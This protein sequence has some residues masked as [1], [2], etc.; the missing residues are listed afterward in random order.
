M[1]TLENL[2]PQG[3][4]NW[5]AK[6]CGIP[7]PSYHEEEL[8]A[9]VA[10]WA[11]EKGYYGGQDKVGNLRLVKPA[12]PGKDHLPSVCL[13]AHFDMVPQS[14]KEF[15]FLTQP[16]TPVVKGNYV[17]ADE[18]TL[19]ADNGIGLASI[20]AIFDDEE[21]V[22]GPLEAILTRNEE[23]SMIG[24]FQLQ[25]NW[26]QSDYLINTD[27]EEIGELYLGCAGGYDVELSR[28]YEFKAL[29]PESKLYRVSLSGFRGGHSG[30][31]IHTNRESA[32]QYLNKALFLTY[33]DVKFNICE[34]FSGQALNAI[35]R[36]ATAV[37]VVRAENQ[38]AFKQAWAK[39]SATVLSIVKLAEENGEFKTEFL[40]TAEEHPEYKRISCSL[41]PNLLGF[42][43]NIPNGV[44][45]KSDV[46]AD[47]IE[48]SLSVGVVRL[49][50]EEGFSYKILARSTNDDAN[51]L[52]VLELQAL[53]QMGGFD[54]KYHGRYPG[55]QP[56]KNAFSDFVA[57]T[58]AEVMN[59]DISVKVIHAGLEC[60]IIKGHYPNMKI[61]SIGPNIYNPHTPKEH[62]D[63]ASTAQYYET[64]RQILGNLEQML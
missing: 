27:S 23:V 26:L 17:Y 39:A 55:W 19:G 61:V 57:K 31:D 54:C 20:L 22:H 62:V 48:T 3:L 56:E 64:L 43:V 40:G 30:C 60:G 24:A 52:Q 36:E 34:Y 58:Y 15:D 21:L 29:K 18:T 59:K 16:I 49:N 46:F 10:N 32:I 14:D 12:S 53:A 28:A 33:Q 25:E 38:E 5:F 1:S 35:S 13:Q 11:K 2:Q 47:T 7:H 6:I 44:R 42:L 9:Y 4:W 63:I 41:M 51:Y 50:Q 45:R 8:V 37:L